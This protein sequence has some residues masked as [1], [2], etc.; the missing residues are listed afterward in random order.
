MVALEMEEAE[1]LVSSSI[2]VGNK[3]DASPSVMDAVL[4]IACEPKN[5]KSALTIAFIVAM[6]LVIVAAN[7]GSFG[8]V[9]I[10]QEIE[11]ELIFVDPMEAMTPLPVTESIVSQKSPGGAIESTASDTPPVR[12]STE[13]PHQTP[14]NEPKEQIKQEPTEGPHEILVEEIKID[15]KQ[16]PTQG[17]YESPT[18]EPRVDIKQESSQGPNDLSSEEP[19]Q[20]IK[21][22]TKTVAPKVSKIPL[23]ELDSQT[24]RSDESVRLEESQKWGSWHFWDGES[25]NRPKEDYCGKY[26]NRDIPGDNFPENSWQVDAVYVNH[27]LND[28]DKLVQRAMEAIFTEYGKGKPLSSAKLSE[29]HRMFHWEKLDFSKSQ[30]PPNEFKSNG[31]RE[32]GGWTTKRSFDGLVRRLLHAMLTEDTFTVVLAG[33]SAAQGQ[34]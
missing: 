5:R 17:P 32:I 11:P 2:G 14:A 27:Y 4:H 16:T 30:D 34:G 28:A 10:T 29:R 8:N 33:H 6:I 21:E 18:E 9:A 15:I 12:E 22:E 25:S 20:E 23:V 3:R 24:G 13:G 26:P 1:S 19:K 7:S 31:S